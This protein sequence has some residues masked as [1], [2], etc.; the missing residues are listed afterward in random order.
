MDILRDRENVMN[1]QRDEL[2][3]ETLSQIL[4][5]AYGTTSSNSHT[6]IQTVDNSGIAIYY[7]NE[8]GIFKYEPEMHELTSIRKGNFTNVLMNNNDNFP[9]DASSAFIFVYKRDEPA[10]DGK[11]LTDL[12]AGINCGAMM[13]NI[14]LAC[15]NLDLACIPIPFSDENKSKI[16]NGINKPESVVIYGIAVGRK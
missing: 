7:L 8:K 11:I 1:L 14:A 3:P 15:S 16:I 12:E 6:A 13:Q 4:W 10:S 9:I 5:S 2:Q